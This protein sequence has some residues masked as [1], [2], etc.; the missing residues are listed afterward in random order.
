MS[1]HRAVLV[2][3]LEHRPE[4]VEEIVEGFAQKTRFGAV[5]DVRQS[6]EPIEVGPR[7]VVRLQ[8]IFCSM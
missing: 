8:D 3:R 7:V 1:N 6:G 4:L 2:M 5:G